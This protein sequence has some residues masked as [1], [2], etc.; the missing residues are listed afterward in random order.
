MMSVA[1]SIALY[2]SAVWFAKALAS[3][4]NKALLR[5]T[6]RTAALRV[7]Q[8][9]R[10]V[11]T[12]AALVL[13][14]SIPWDLKADEARR[15]WGAGSAGSKSEERNRTIAAWQ[16][17]WSAIPADA[18]GA[19]VR[20]LIPDIQKWLDRPGGEIDHF[21]T[22]VITGHGNF[23]V[24]LQRIGKT[25]SDKCLQCDLDV[26]D[27]P[28]HTLL[29]CPSWASSRA[30]ATRT[31][32]AGWTAPLPESICDF[33]SLIVSSVDAWRWGASLAASILKDKGR[34]Q[35]RHREG[36]SPG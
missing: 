27:D 17:E 19:R 20:D 30:R 3:N 33:A 18:P 31:N 11:S 5:R 7:I 10:T 22:Q 34:L 24:Y 23:Q 16:A 36:A 29:V 14:R 1:E 35:R 28:V 8:G 6:Q 13:A 12:S 2:G 32:G 21:L 15:L 4:G 9:Y 25:P 26:A